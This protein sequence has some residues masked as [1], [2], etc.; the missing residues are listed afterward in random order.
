MY[1]DNSRSDWYFGIHSGWLQLAPC[2]VIGE[3]LESNDHPCHTSQVNGPGH[4]RKFRGG[5]QLWG[6]KFAILG[7]GPTATYDLTQDKIA[8][9]WRGGNFEVQLCDSQPM[10]G[11][12]LPG[13]LHT[14]SPPPRPTTGKR[15]PKT[16]GVVVGHQNIAY[17]LGRSLESKKIFACGA[18]ENED[19]LGKHRL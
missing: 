13:D 9:L 6:A 15:S 5:G 8:I 2:L 12:Y 17:D 3:A 4:V 19:D 18:R 7:L 16:R 14:P 10:T 11:G 1:N